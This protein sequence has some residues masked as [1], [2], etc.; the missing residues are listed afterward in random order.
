MV[1]DRRAGIA[2]G[3]TGALLLLLALVMSATAVPAAA[4]GSSVKAW[5]APERAARRPNPLAK[6]PEVV[7]RGES[8]FHRDCAQC[9]GTS[10]HGDGPQAATLQPAPADLSSARVQSQT[11]GALFWKMSQGRGMMPAA[12]LS[13][14]DKWA[15]VHFLRSLST[16]R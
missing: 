14:G 12:A 7:K 16:P 8:L 2:V 9:H 10:G 5:A 13:D 1:I 3:R 15:V 11:D 6:T 4:Q